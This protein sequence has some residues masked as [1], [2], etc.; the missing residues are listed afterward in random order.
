MRSATVLIIA[1]M[2][3]CGLNRVKPP[4]HELTELHGR[5]AIR[6]M[7]RP[8]HLRTVPAISHR[9][10][11]TRLALGLDQTELCQRAGIAR[12]TWNQW[13]KGKGRPQL[14][15]AMKLVDAFG[16]TLDW[17]YLGDVNGLPHGLVLRLNTSAIDNRIAP[18]G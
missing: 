6:A 17:I 18:A 3:S 16:L 7:E 4:E 13:E 1:P 15:E 10:R 11:L 9:L 2:I 5:C 14:D 12:N 8:P